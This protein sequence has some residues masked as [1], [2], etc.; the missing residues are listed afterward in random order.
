M[1]L[2]RLLKDRRA[3]VAPMFALAL[4]ALITAAG[5]AVD[6]TMA[7]KIRTQLL[8]AADAASIGSVGKSSAALA[9]A[10]TMSSD[11]PISAGQPRQRRSSMPSSPDRTAIR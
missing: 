6:Y 10:A 5:S 1:L 9:A 2:R 8:A 4:I 11:G 7:A 3:A